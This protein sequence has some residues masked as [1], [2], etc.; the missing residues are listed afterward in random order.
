M[1]CVLPHKYTTWVRFEVRAT[2]RTIPQLKSMYIA[3]VCFLLT[4]LA[5][6][7]F[8]PS[9]VKEYVHTSEAAA[10]HTHT[11]TCTALSIG[12]GLHGF[13][14]GTSAREVR[15]VRAAASSTWDF[16]SAISQ[17]G[18]E[19]PG[20]KGGGG[21]GEGRGDQSLFLKSFRPPPIYAHISRPSWM[22]EGRCTHTHMHK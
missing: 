3:S 5:K 9:H 12:C 14:A 7:C 18:M 6:I 21:E 16:I 10:A 17:D 20:E 8:W 13:Y 22:D 4:R 15:Y 1:Q 19:G 2:N 11:H